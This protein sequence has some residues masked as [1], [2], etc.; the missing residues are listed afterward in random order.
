MLRRQPGIERPLGNAS[1][2]NIHIACAG[3]LQDDEWE[4]ASA[5]EDD[6]D[7]NDGSTPSSSTAFAGNGHSSVFR[8]IEDF[9]TLLSEDF[10]EGS[11]IE[12]PDAKNDPINNV[13]VSEYAIKYLKE[14]ARR[15]HAAFLA[16]CQGL[17]RTQ[18][19][20]IQAALGVGN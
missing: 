9:A 13:N 2:G 8:P 10:A 16:C 15:D 5:D 20:A 3:L 1:L 6:D 12:D 14:L 18:Q 4:E 19:E 17:N 11:Y 7:E